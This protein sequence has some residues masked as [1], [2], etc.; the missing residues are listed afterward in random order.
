M[1]NGQ[2]DSH[3]YD[4]IIDLPC[5]ISKTRPHMSILDRAAQFSPFAALSG[6]D[7]AVK[8]AMRFT[9]EQP[10]L[11]EDSREELDRKLALLREHLHE[12]PEVRIV[13][14]QPDD[15]KEGGEYQMVRGR[16]KRI[17]AVEHKLIM[18][19]GTALPMESIIQ[20]DD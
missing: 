9:E 7:D 1:R 16:M 11:A 19:D 15:R 20:I 6:Y 14:F 18:E 8:E 5:H 2:E 10:E 3:R 12:R 17:D 4:D 13:F